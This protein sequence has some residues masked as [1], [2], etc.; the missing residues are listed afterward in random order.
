MADEPK[1]M[2]VPSGSMYIAIAQLRGQA[3]TARWQHAVVFLVLN[4]P[5]A[6][7]VR[8]LCTSVTQGRV[9]FLAALIGSIGIGLNRLWSGLVK[10]ENRWIHF[11]TDILAS[12]ERARGTE[13][14]VLVF[15]SEDFP[16]TLQTIEGLSFRRGIQ[17]LSLSM[18]CLWILTSVVLFVWGVYMTGAGKL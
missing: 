18:M 8:E 9:L 14:G 17:L 6:N 15:A 5:L 10:R 4:V 12:I 7:W 3:S 11:Y 2:P 1:G 13:S 16:S